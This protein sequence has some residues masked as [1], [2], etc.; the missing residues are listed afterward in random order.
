MPRRLRVAL[1]QALPVEADFANPK[2]VE[3]AIELARRSC[4]YEPD[5]IVFPEYFPF[6]DS[7]DLLR[8]AVDCGAYIVAGVAYSERG[9]LYNT[10]TVYSPKGR[11]ALRQGKRN[12]GRLE[13]RLWG[14]KPWPHPYAVLDIGRAKLGIA[15]CADFWSIPEA[16]TELFLAGAEVFINPSYM[17]SLSHHW[18]KAN[19]TRSL[20]YYVPVVGVDTA[21]FEFRS[22]RFRFR[23]GGLSHVIVPPS[24][25]EEAE[26][27][28]GTGA[29]STDSWLRLVMGRDEEVRVY[30]IDVEGTSTMRRDWWLRM[31]GVE[32][33]TWI[34][35][36]IERGYPSAKVV[37]D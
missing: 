23:G 17:F 28:W 11:I 8:E 14:F 34:R 30:D 24:S 6:H 25:P 27:W 19:L 22:K 10:A 16:A 2:N 9:A 26:K 15:V 36:R 33:D 7:E 37:K 31:R 12:I 21:A 35:S 13:A 3:H 18:V 4:R 32:L 5:V 20:E 1:V 29:E